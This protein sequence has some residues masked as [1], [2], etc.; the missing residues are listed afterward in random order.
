MKPFLKQEE[1]ASKIIAMSKAS[2]KKEIGSQASDV[3]KAK[4]LAQQLETS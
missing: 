3:E 1:S 4:D 2:D